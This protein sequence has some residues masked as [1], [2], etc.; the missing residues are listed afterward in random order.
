MVRTPPCV[1]RGAARCQCSRL[2]WFTGCVTLGKYYSSLSLYEL[3]SKVKK[4]FSVRLH[5]CEGEWYPLLIYIKHGR[6][7]S[8]KIILAF[9]GSNI[10]HATLYIDN[11][12]LQ[13]VNFSNLGFV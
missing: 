7:Y 9:S 11:F 8:M 2:Q 5:F 4:I 3:I 12:T 1:D 6:I 10:S 13:G